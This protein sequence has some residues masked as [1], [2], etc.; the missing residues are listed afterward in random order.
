M[1]HPG[2][3]HGWNLQT[4]PN[5]EEDHLS[6]TSHPTFFVDFYG[7][8]VGKYTIPIDPMGMVFPHVVEKLQVRYPSF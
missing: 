8:L 5:E 2:K 6:Q 1:V 4:A 3:F 7:K